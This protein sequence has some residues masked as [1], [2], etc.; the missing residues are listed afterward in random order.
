LFAPL[1]DRMDDNCFDNS[2]IKELFTPILTEASNITF[3]ETENLTHIYLSEIEDIK[4][5]VFMRSNI[6]TVYAPNLK[7]INLFD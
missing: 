2:L 1:L 3:Y 4:G 5:A 7:R 6:D